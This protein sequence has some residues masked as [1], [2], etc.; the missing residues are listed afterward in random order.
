M[1]HCLILRTRYYTLAPGVNEI[2][3]ERRDADFRAR[4]DTFM[5]RFLYSPIRAGRRLDDK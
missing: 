5:T 1:C 4:L 3:N 2:F